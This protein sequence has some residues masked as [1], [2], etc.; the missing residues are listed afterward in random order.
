M[1]PARVQ[2]PSSEELGLEPLWG[3][4]ACPTEHVHCLLHL[5]CS[6]EQEQPLQAWKNGQDRI[7]MCF[8]L[9]HDSKKALRGSRLVLLQ[10]VTEQHG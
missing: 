10:E 7:A 2:A 6:V 1:H 5:S 3:E 8:A 4:G 9:E